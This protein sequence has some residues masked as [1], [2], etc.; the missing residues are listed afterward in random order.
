MK[1]TNN[2]K[3]AEVMKTKLNHI[4]AE[5]RLLNKKAKL[6]DLNM[7]IAILEAENAVA[8]GEKISRRLEAIKKSTSTKVTAQPQSSSLA[9]LPFM[10][11]FG[12]IL[13][14][15]VLMLGSL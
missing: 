7:Q 12:S 8:E 9:F 10:V 5:Q 15:A 11:V 2:K 6:A 3:N 4:E 14:L 1:K 13:L